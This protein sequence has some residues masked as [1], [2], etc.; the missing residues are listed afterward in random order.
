MG[1]GTIASARVPSHTKQY[2]GISHTCPDSFALCLV[3]GYS[4]VW[5]S[6]S[7]RRLMATTNTAET[8]ASSALTLPHSVPS[9]LITHV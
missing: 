3:V 2:T 6:W 7:V 4:V 5:A 9:Q 8:S 1:A